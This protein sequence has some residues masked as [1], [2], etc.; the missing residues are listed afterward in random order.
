MGKR[1]S[2]PATALRSAELTAAEAD[3][4]EGGALLPLR[5]AEAEAA[6]GLALGAG[7]AAGLN[8]AL[9]SSKALRAAEAEEAEGGTADLRSANLWLAKA[10]AEAAA[11]E[12]E[13]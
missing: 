11:E 5:A 9:S 6:G 7:R 3:A 4:E 10:E 2:K 1:R 13:G 12:A 8:L